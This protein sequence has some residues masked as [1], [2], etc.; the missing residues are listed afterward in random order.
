MILFAL[1][2]LALWLAFYQPTRHP[3]VDEQ[4]YCRAVD[5]DVAPVR[6]YTDQEFFDSPFYMPGPVIMWHYTQKTR[7]TDHSL[8]GLTRIQT[9]RFNPQVHRW[10]VLCQKAAGQSN[11][12]PMYS[13]PEYHASYFNTRRAAREA[14]N[15]IKA[16]PFMQWDSVR[17][18]E[19]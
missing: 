6:K 19:I 4:A 3:T 5:D 10:Y 13:A 18:Y 7:S 15:K 2:V 8:V 12:H 11:Y 17:V 1:F 14:M 9:H 16:N